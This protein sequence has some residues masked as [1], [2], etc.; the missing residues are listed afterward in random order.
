MDSRK[1]LVRHARSPLTAVLLAIGFVMRAAAGSADIY[2]ECLLDA[3]RYDE[4]IWHDAAG[5]GRPL[6]S[7]YFGDGNSDGNGG[8]RGSCGMAVAY[9][10]LVRASPVSDP[11]RTNRLERK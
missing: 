2:L 3:E 5:A 10:V 7:G 8:I 4:S 6:N 9:A 11:R 1:V